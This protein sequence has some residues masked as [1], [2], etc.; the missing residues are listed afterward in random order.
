MVDSFKI[1]RYLNIGPVCD[2]LLVAKY[3]LDSCQGRKGRVR[4]GT[5]KA[6]IG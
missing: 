6:K 5:E 4:G 3:I 1:E 2:F